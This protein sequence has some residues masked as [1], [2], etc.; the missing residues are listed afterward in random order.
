MSHSDELARRYRRLLR[1]Y[2]RAYRAEYE[3]E[4][5]GVLLDAAPDGR[6][7][8]AAGVS[9]NLLAGAVRVHLRQVAGSFTRPVWGDAAAIVSVLAP[10]M[11]ATAFVRA[12]YPRPCPVPYLCGVSYSGGEMFGEG[13]LTEHRLTLPLLLYGSLAVAVLV[14]CG[15]R[16]IAAAISLTVAG[17]M[18]DQYI[19][20]QLPNLE[21]GNADRLAPMTMICLAVL[22]AAALLLSP[23][24]R[25]CREL[26]GTRRILIAVAGAITFVIVH[27]IAF[28]QYE[29][30]T[31]LW[32]WRAT[33]AVL[34][35]GAIVVLRGPAAR[36]ALLFLTLG[37]GIAFAGDH[38]ARYLAILGT[39]PALSTG[40]VGIV[41]LD[42]FWWLYLAVLAVFIALAAT[43]CI[44]RNKARFQHRSN[45]PAQA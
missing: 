38:L 12:S 3:A 20:W 13:T 44:N 31:H 16:W 40:Y 21:Y 33:V 2:P 24:P 30:V 19:T 8:P 29:T 9:V 45:E 28:A 34:A 22:A 26:L 32:L 39:G 36:R 27:A 10:L 37:V 7:H 23:G 42:A 17:R 1:L 6:R 15:R 41:P 25:R 11:L 14:L 35:V 4:M 5:L 18:V 43:N